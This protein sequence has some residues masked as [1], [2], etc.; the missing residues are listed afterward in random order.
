MLQDIGVVAGVKSV[1]ITQHG[2]FTSR[3]GVE[4]G[5]RDGPGQAAATNTDE[6]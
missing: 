6:V 2:K 1:A 3:M 4:I 5:W